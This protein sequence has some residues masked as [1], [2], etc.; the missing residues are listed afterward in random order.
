MKL[1]YKH[2]LVACFIGYITQAITINFIP[3]LFVT[4]QNHYHIPLS[5]IT[6]LV[7]VNFL[8][9]LTV[10]VLTPLFEK[11]VGYRVCMVAAHL[12]SA[13][14][15]IMLTVLPEVL[16]PFVGLLISVTTYAIGGGLLEVLVSP[17]TESCPTDNKEKAMS[18]LHSFY[19]WGSMGVVLLS[20]LFFRLAGIE[21]WKILARIWAVI[22][23]LNSLVFSRTPIAPLIAEG[24]KGMSLK[25]LMHSR[26]FWLFMMMMICAGASEHSIGQWSS[27]FA[28][29]GLGIS[30]AAGDLAGPMA[31][32]ALMGCVRVFFSKN[33][34]KIDLE[35][36]LFGSSIVCFVAFLMVVLVPNPVVNLIGCAL[37]GI[38][39]SMLWPGTLSRASAKLP[40]GG[41]TMFALLAVGGDIGC[42]LGPTLLGMVADASNGNLKMGM[43]AGTVFPLLLVICGLFGKKM[44]K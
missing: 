31:F 29:M 16:P 18:L 17:I 10:D 38:G 13:S 24:E 22:P 28:E 40:L 44:K 26:V 36:F 41:T 2:T 1:T 11:Q 23:L 27:T 20:T 42:T 14:G 35:K 21:N 33:S 7:T 39:V 3:L 12:F 9:Q 32:A 30:K 19:S 15:L 37:S 43:L 8:V 6:I 25:E 34:D 5:Q 4:F